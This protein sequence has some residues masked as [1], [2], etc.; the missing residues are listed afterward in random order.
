MN[1]STYFEEARN[2]FEAESDLRNMIYVYLNRNITNVSGAES[3]LMNISTYFEEMRNDFEAEEHDLCIFEC[4][5]V[6]SS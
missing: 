3:D 1:I 5:I 4:K 6:Y 2:D